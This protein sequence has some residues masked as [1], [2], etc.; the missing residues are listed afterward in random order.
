MFWAVNDISCIKLVQY[1]KYL[2]N[3]V[4]TDGLVLKHQGIS[5]FSVDY[6]LV[7]FWLF[8]S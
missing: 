1:N 3:I 7:R 6:S 5:S 8:L 2:L 4:D